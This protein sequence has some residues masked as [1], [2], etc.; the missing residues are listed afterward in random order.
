MLPVLLPSSPFQ[1]ITFSLP[2]SLSLT[3]R[4]VAEATFPAGCFCQHQS[5]EQQR[6]A[7]ALALFDTL[8]SGTTTAHVIHLVG[9]CSSLSL[10]AGGAQ[11]IMPV[12]VGLLLLSRASAARVLCCR[13]RAGLLCCQGSMGLCSRD[14]DCLAL[15]GTLSVP[16]CNTVL[17]AQTLSHRTC[18]SWTVKLLQLLLTL[19]AIGQYFRAWPFWS[20]S[21]GGLLCTR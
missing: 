12:I 1:A 7:G 20:T 15:W 16:T 14:V 21:M 19:R 13:G 3:H 8:A 11:D 9:P 4:L 18:T 5:L 10:Q 17:A 2:L 6:H